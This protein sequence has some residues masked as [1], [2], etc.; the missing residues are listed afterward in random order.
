MQGRDG[1]VLK[2]QDVLQSIVSF[3]NETPD[4]IRRIGSGYLY[5]FR[6]FVVII[7]NNHVV[8]GCKNLLNPKI[9]FLSNIKPNVRTQKLY[10]GDYQSVNFDQFEWYN[11]P[12]D[13]WFFK[14]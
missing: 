6:K 10:L 1:M 13:E 11:H 7:T 12:R 3:G 14:N 8:A 4:G 2:I 9:F 5:H